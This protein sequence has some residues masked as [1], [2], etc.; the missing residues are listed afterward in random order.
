MHLITH[1]KVVPEGSG[2]PGLPQ[3]G[4]CMTAAQTESLSS[5]PTETIPDKASPSEQLELAA[6]AAT[7]ACTPSSASRPVHYETPF[8]L[9]SSAE[10]RA[11]MQEL[12]DAA[13][14]ETRL[15]LLP[16]PRLVF[17]PMHA[18]FRNV[19]LNRGT[20]TWGQE[21]TRHRLL[22]PVHEYAEIIQREAQAAAKASAAAGTQPK[23][24]VAVVHV[25]GASVDCQ[26]LLTS[27]NMQAQHALFTNVD[28]KQSYT[29][30]VFLIFGAHMILLWLSV[31]CAVGC[32]TDW[33]LGLLQA[34]CK[35]HTCCC[36]RHTDQSHCPQD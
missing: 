34:C 27:M 23:S 1:T 18:E 36:N 21:E 22:M 16:A 3:Q 17:D 24:A 7:A 15:A 32:R 26:S 29:A 10:K 30:S 8:L 13:S 6:T 31:R 33:G 19:T 12:W 11:V 28:L 35:S 4:A 25:E 5:Q 20:V 14:E 9:T 2:Q